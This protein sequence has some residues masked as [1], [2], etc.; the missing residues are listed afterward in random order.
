M[1]LRNDLTLE[2]SNLK[3]RHWAE[4]FKADIDAMEDSER[5][6][7]FKYLPKW[8]SKEKS[9]RKTQLI[10]SRIRSAHFIKV[11]TID[12]FN[13]KYSKATEGVE[14]NY[15]TLFNSISRE[16]LPSAI[17]YGPSGVG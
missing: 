6:I 11:K 1:D 7:F 4:L 2:L 13:F 16:C 8:I 12:N 9:E 3:L 17:F 14:K 15:R 5:K 10:S